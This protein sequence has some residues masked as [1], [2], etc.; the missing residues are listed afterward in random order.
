MS[1]P[2]P[3]RVPLEPILVIIII[4]RAMLLYLNVLRIVRDTALPA[5]L[6]LTQDD[7]ITKVQLASCSGSCLFVCN[8]AA[9]R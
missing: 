6:D 5:G 3:I 9:D 4:I 8:I 1:R 7:D 2:T